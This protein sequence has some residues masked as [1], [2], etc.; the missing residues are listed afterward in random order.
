MNTF[1]RPATEAKRVWM[2]KRRLLSAFMERMGF[3]RRSIRI[4]VKSPF[5]KLASSIMLITTIKKSI[6]F[7][8]LFRRY[9]FLCKTKPMAITLSTNSIKK[10]S[11]NT[12][13]VFSTNQSNLVSSYSLLIL[14]SQFSMAIKSEFKSIASVI[15]RLNHFHSTNHTTAMRSLFS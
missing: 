1:T 13:T 15:K 10:M 5:P 6:R 14:L 8:Q 12:I 9:D 2:R 4:S 7:H 11:E 3:K